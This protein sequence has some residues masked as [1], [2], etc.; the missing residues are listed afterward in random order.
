MP[1]L[2]VPV[3][4]V[5]R[6]ARSHQH[7]EQDAHRPHK[8]RRIQFHRHQASLFDPRLHGARQRRRRNAGGRRTARPPPELNDSST[9]IGWRTPLSY[10]TRSAGSSA[11]MYLPLESVTVVGAIT[12]V[13]VL[14]NCAHAKEGMSNHRG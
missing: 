6:L 3:E 8:S 14:L 13:E 9:C 10:S 5:L 12:S 2:S 7:S 11:S 4:P 1:V